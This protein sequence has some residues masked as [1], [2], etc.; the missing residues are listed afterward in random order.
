MDWSV[1]LLVYGVLMVCCLFGGVLIGSAIGIVGIVGVTMATGTRM[2]PTFGDIIWNTATS[3]TLVAIPL[4]VLMGE[5]ILRSGLARRFYNGIA[6]MLRGVPG[7]LA[8][9]NIVG[10]AAFSALSGS[11]VATALTV[12]TVAVPEMRRRGY[13]DALTLGSL[14]GGGCLGILIPP[15]IPMIVY[16]SITQ[17]SVLSVF[18]AG[19]VPGLVL[20]ALFLV[21]IAIRVLLNRDLAPP[22]DAEDLK[23][24]RRSGIVD[25]LPVAAL[26]AAVIG[27]MYAGVV[28][29]TE[30]AAFGCL[31]ALLLGLVYRDL[32]AA[33]LV[34]ALRNAV[35]TSCVVMF[36]TINAQFLSFAI[37][38]S[39]ISRGLSGA[40]ADAGIGPFAFFLL[41]IALYAVIGMFIDGLSIMLLTVP[42]L[43]PVF[44]VMGYDPIW[45]GVVLVLLIELGAL[46]PPMG[47][48]LFAVQS[49]S[50]APL[51]VIGRSSMPYALIIVAFCL[52]LYLEPDIALWLPRATH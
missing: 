31:L 10:C 42:V 24:K 20:A 19:V 44:Q 21:Y 18:M 7:A 48:N 50:N 40:M 12:G 45:M 3:F 11:T 22:P 9:T 43:F 29:P 27:G 16:A 14:T 33:A 34:A 28:T 25:S 30:A 38:N 51:G 36:I 37:V 26:I 17:T 4:F 47:L 2:W 6:V 35:V 5:I 41:L 13:K 39:G 23:R 46:T 1:A 8:H 15:S 52:A 32:S 49:I